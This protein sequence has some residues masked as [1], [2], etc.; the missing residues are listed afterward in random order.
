VKR[1]YILCCDS[2]PRSL[3]A[4]IVLY[5]KTRWIGD[6]FLRRI[7]Q[8]RGKGAAYSS[9]LLDWE[10]RVGVKSKGIEGERLR[11]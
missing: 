5:S 10:R 2:L 8:G 11:D 6:R 3:F 7:E 1:K 9:F 4:E